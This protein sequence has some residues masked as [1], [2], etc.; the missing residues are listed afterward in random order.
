VHVL[1]QDAV[2]VVSGCALLPDGTICVA[3]CARSKLVRMSPRGDI[4]G[5]V[6]MLD[7]WPRALA[8]TREAVFVTSMPAGVNA[9]KENDYPSSRV[10]RV[11]MSD[12]L[13]AGP[14]AP[15][16]ASESVELQWCQLDDEEAAGDDDDW[17]GD[18]QPD[19]TPGVPVSL[20]A[21]A[22]RLFVLHRLTEVGARPW[23]YVDTEWEESP[24]E[25]AAEQRR[26]KR[27]LPLREHTIS[28]FE[29]DGTR[30]SKI[31]SLGEW[32]RY[33]APET[34]VAHDGVLYVNQKL[35]I[36]VFSTTGEPL[37]TFSLAQPQWLLEPGARRV[38]LETEEFAVANGRVY[39]RDGTALRVCDLDGNLM[40]SV[41]LVPDSR[42]DKHGI[43]SLA[44]DGAHARKIRVRWCHGLLVDDR[45]LRFFCHGCALPPWQREGRESLSFFGPPWHPDSPA[46]LVL[47]SVGIRGVA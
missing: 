46:A 40:Q 2:V 23:E 15:S 24:A 25:G 14:A 16:V 17:W 6:S 28:I 38:P 22:Q 41:D 12:L 13:N 5:Q 7:C 3:A 18:C 21:T 36:G 39:S 47:R 27:A 32:P 8:A 35:F 26:V 33:K 30:P 10:V 37:R 4:L 29:N 31:F 34:L 1:A 42:G 45:S 43:R 20:A 19:V 9:A 44:G 11:A